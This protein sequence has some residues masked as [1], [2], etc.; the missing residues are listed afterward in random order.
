[1]KIYDLNDINLNRFIYSEPVTNFFG[2][3]NIYIDYDKA[4][5]ED[6]KIR[7]QTPKCS[8]PFGLNKNKY[9]DNADIS[10][11]LDLNLVGNTPAMTKFKSFLEEFDER[12]VSMACTNSYKWFNKRI[13]KNIV[14]SLYKKQLNKT[15]NY[16]EKLRVKLNTKDGLFTGDVFDTYS[17]PSNVDKITKGTYVQAILECSG[18][19]FSPS[20]GFGVGWKVIQLMIFPSKILGEFAFQDDEEDEKEDI[21]PI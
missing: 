16:P 17:N 9:E 21:Q 7:I 4:N 19:W 1:M 2:R 3:H 20:Q 8:L 12:N 6:K 5:K 11:S 13:D 10:L 15:T 18:L 14:E